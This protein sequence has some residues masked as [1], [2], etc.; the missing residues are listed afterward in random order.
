MEYET[1]VLLIGPNGIKI[2]QC[3]GDSLG[4]DLRVLSPCCGEEIHF[5]FTSKEPNDRWVCIGCSTEVVPATNTYKST[6][7]RSAEFF[8]SGEKNL[9]N[10]ISV[11]TGFAAENIKVTVK[12]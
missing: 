3:F 4:Y 10:W 5:D 12:K 1:K 9:E 8:R 2:A 7:R 6:S 11:W